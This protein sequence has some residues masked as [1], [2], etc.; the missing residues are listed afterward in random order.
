MLEL[1]RLLNPEA[2]YLDGDMR[3]VLLGKLYDCVVIHDAISYMLKEEDLRAAFQTAQAH[4]KPGGIFLTLVE[5][6]PDRFQQNRVVHYSHAT[7]GLE[8]TSV[9]YYY[10][11][12]INDTTYGIVFT[13][14]IRQ[15]GTLRV[16]L[17]NHTCGIFPMSVWYRS[18]KAA[19][20]SDS[21]E[22][23]FHAVQPYD[24]SFTVLVAFNL[25]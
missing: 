17:D 5:E 11:P 20:L 7:N 22:E 25:K 23:Y 4:L 14:F 1:A 2:A 9:E 10:D 21:R 8:I 19:G 15:N 13:Y 6:T 16:E 24:S 12:D 18:L 3:T